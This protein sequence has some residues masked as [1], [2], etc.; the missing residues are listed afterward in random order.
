MPSV[1]NNK[2]SAQALRN[3]LAQLSTEEGLE[4]TVNRIVLA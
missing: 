1:I 3:D 2:P 4:L